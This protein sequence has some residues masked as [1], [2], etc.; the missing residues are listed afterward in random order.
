MTNLI[1]FINTI[2]CNYFYFTVVVTVEVGVVEG[3]ANEEDLVTQIKRLLKNA[4]PDQI[5]AVRELDELKEQGVTLI[6][7]GL[8]SIRLYFSCRDDKSLHVLKSWLQNGRLLELVESLLISLT[9]SRSSLQLKCDDKQFNNGM[10]YFSHRK[11]IQG[12]L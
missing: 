8:G 11:Q 1:K 7:A 3:A 10:L 4:T 2:L 5:L 6:D 12:K 9:S